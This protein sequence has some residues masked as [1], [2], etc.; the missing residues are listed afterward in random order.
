MKNINLNRR[1]LL[2]G[3]GA[4]GLATA[5]YEIPGV[6]AEALVTTPEQTEGPYYP[7]NLPLDTDNDLL[8]INNNI[9]PAV[10][11][12]TY[13]SG[14][15]LDAKGD[16]IRNAIVEIWQCDSSGAYLHS[17]DTNQ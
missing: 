11:E 8:V 15:I 3:L 10:G 12:V 16:P 5:F 2:T 14:R 1:R 4:M 17:K 6:F 7:P 9:T 13:V